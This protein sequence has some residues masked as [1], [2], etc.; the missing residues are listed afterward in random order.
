MDL[1]TVP[2]PDSMCHA[3]VYCTFCG[4]RTMRNMAK[5]RDVDVIFRMR[6]ADVPKLVTEFANSRCAFCGEAMGVKVLGDEPATP[7]REF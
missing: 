6:R 5:G 4:N 3:L 7:I 2:A 1:V